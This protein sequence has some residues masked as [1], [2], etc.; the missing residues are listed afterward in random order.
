[1]CILSS[2]DVHPHLTSSRQNL[3]KHFSKL[4]MTWLVA[5]WAEAR[6]TFVLLHIPPTVTKCIFFCVRINCWLHEWKSL[7]TNWISHSNLFSQ[8][9]SYTAV[10]FHKLNH[11]QQGRN[12]DLCHTASVRLCKLPEIQHGSSSWHTFF[13][14]SLPSPVVPQH[15][16][17]P[18]ECWSEEQTQNFSDSNS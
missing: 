12:E 15:G 10:S 16:S 9:E 18:T 7:F 6:Y 3:G 17:F 2:N 1:M 4:Y 13:S 11:T 5:V 14:P 8:T